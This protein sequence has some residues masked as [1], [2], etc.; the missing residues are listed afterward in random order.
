MILLFKIYTQKAEEFPPVPDFEEGKR[1][2]KFPG[3]ALETINRR[4]HFL[5]GV[6]RNRRAM[7]LMAC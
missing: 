6:R 4:R 5:G 1:I 3:G 7:R 2:L